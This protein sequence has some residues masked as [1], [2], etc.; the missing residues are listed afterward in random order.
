M[1]L[2]Y[3][4]HLKE[5]IQAW[6]ILRP[7]L[8]KHDQPHF[9]GPRGNN[10]LSLGGNNVCWACNFKVIDVRKKAHF[11]QEASGG[12]PERPQGEGEGQM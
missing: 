9:N 2:T 6:S 3:K 11:L 5:D 7:L 12:K 4:N 1:L 10:I 8:Q